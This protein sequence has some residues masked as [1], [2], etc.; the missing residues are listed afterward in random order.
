MKALVYEGKH[1]VNIR[2]VPK[3]KLGPDDVLLKIRSVGICGT[4]LHIYN[5]GT[6]VKRGTI[7]GHEFSGVIAAVGKNV[8]QLKVGMRAVG[9]HVATCGKCFY[10]LRGK[11]NL[12]LRA[13]IYGL[14]LPGALSEFMV[15]PAR[16]VYQIPTSVSFDEGAMI[17][18]LT[19]ALYAASQAGFLL[20][21]RVA[22]VGQGPIGLLLD[23][24]LEAAGAH[25]IGIDVIDSRL[26]FAKKQGWA[27]VTL[28]PTKKV[29]QAELKKISSIGVDSSFEVVGKETTA[30]LCL[31]IT[32]R[33]GNVFMLGVYEQPA[34]LNLMRIIK[35]ELN[36][37]G[38]WTCAFSFP[39]SIDLVA[40]KKI[41]LKSLVTHRY[42][43]NDAAKALADASVYSGNRIKT[44]IQL[45]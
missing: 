12:C 5:G 27:H 29:F 33:D 17:E 20:E 8:N 41:D 36:L 7:I 34:T 32:R 21:Q 35:K 19:I 6:D 18:P 31:D 9:E 45:S 44:V 43:F 23:Q 4:D 16:L 13:Q 24:V 1:R 22:V 40:E 38:S 28:N 37:F 3:P 42:P 25:V 26:A 14:D 11:P 10:C 15:L 30:A 2:E 39:A